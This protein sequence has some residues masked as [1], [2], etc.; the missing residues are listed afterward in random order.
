MKKHYS[1]HPTLTL[2]HQEREE[3]E[4]K[5]KQ[6]DAENAA[7]YEQFVQSFGGGGADEGKT[8]LRGDITGGASSPRGGNPGTPGSSASGAASPSVGLP[9]SFSLLAGKSAAGAGA[10]SGAKPALPLA[11]AGWV[12]S[13]RVR[14]W[15]EG[16]IES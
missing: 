4:E 6:A 5:K 12:R 2:T 10:G 15:E 14:G 7:I 3:K 8:F 13:G 1:V 11:L 9:A 16:G